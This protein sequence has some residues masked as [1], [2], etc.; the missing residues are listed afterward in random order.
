MT[1]A[2]TGAPAG[3]TANAGQ[4]D[5]WNS[6]AGERWAQWQPA[7]DRSMAE[8]TDGL[9]RAA[10]ARP[11]E[12]VLDIGCGTGTTSLLLRDAVGADG[13]VD[14][15]DVSAPMLEVAQR[16]AAQARAAIRFLQ[17][18][19]TDHPFTPGYDLLFSRF[20]V[21]FFAD[22]VAAFANLRRA[23][24]RG[25]RLV[26]LCWRE[27]ADNPW[28]TVPLAAA[29]PYLPPEPAAEPHAPGPFAFADPQRIRRILGDAGFARIDAARLDARFW[30]GESADAAAGQAMTIGP[31]ARAAA[32]LGQSPREQI[33]AAVRGALEA[34]CTPGGVFAGAACWL[35][36][37]AVE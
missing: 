32:E 33:R 35:V 1:A 18:D 24:R 26:F 29:R 15:I 31:L 4:I 27:Q 13:A 7:I 10:A 30:M 17:A 36:R 9:M 20:G 16:R 21:M 37:A 19:A 5:Y 14:A 11:G 2:P 6:R 22:P 3:G 12:R 34:Y 25:A 23:G 8:L 28:V